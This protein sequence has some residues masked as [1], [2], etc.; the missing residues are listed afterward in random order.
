MIATDSVADQTYV[1]HNLQPDTTYM[2]LVRAKN[3][4]GMSLPSPVTAP[5]K[6]KSERFRIKYLTSRMFVSQASIFCVAFT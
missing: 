5:V 6:T 2:F 1:V 4:H 3:S